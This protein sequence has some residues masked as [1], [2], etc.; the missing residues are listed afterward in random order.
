MSQRQHAPC[1]RHMLLS[2]ITQ[3]TCRY[4]L[5]HSPTAAQLLHI[6]LQLTPK[7]VT[8]TSAAPNLT[9]SQASRTHCLCTRSWLCAQ[10]QWSQPVGGCTPVACAASVCP[11]AWGFCN[12]LA[13]SRIV[14]MKTQALAHNCSPAQRAASLK[15]STDAASQLLSRPSCGKSSLHKQQQSCK[16]QLSA[17]KQD[18]YGTLWQP[19]G[20]A[21][22]TPAHRTG[23]HPA[24]NLSPILH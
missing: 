1:I 13:A 11:H 22:V 20:E 7:P 17:E 6:N 3:P 24:G 4:R 2:P 5:V 8:T 12:A 9:S 21:G 15:H 10:L 14:G 19:L 18:N 23:L 16:D